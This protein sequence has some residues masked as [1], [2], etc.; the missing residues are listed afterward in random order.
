MLCFCG[1]DKAFTAIKVLVK[2]TV[3]VIKKQREAVAE[4]INQLVGD[5]GIAA[6][7]LIG[8]EREVEDD[9]TPLKAVSARETTWGRDGDSIS[10]K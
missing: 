5:R 9:D 7:S 10:S 1:E 3:M 6:A 2:V 8:R 4:L